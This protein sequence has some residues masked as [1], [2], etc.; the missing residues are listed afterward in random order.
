MDCTR[1]AEFIHYSKFSQAMKITM[2]DRE[3]PLFQ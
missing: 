2:L 1:S 3:K